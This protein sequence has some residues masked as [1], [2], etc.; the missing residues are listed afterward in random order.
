M[1]GNATVPVGGAGGLAAPGYIQLPSL[2]VTVWSGTSG[3]PGSRLSAAKVTAKDTGCNVTRTLTTST[4]TNGQ[5]PNGGDIGLPYGTYDVC[6]QNSAGTDK[7]IITGVALTT[8]GSTGT[9]LDVFLGSQPN[10]TCP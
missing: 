10:G 9:T 4:N 1:L 7:R 8:V 3:S 6:A 2:Q 5:V